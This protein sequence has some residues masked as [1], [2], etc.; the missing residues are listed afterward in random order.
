VLAVSPSCRPSALLPQLAAALDKGRPQ[1]VF[2]RRESGK[3]TLRAADLQDGVDDGAA[4]IA[5]F[6][7]QYLAG[8]VKLADVFARLSNEHLGRL[9]TVAKALS[10]RGIKQ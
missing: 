1:I 5:A 9:A 10:Y 3:Y 7:R 6:T 2:I 4:A 8:A